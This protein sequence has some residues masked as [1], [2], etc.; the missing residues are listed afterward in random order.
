MVR[1]G[2][3]GP[4]LT[5]CTAP[6]AILRAAA[7]LPGR[8]QAPVPLAQGTADAQGLLHVRLPAIPRALDRAQSVGGKRVLQLQI[9]VIATWQQLTN[10]QVLAFTLTG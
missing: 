5:A 7:L 6:G 10:K 2:T 4:W 9:E 3:P 8:T 1:N